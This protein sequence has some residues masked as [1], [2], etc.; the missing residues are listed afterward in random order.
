MDIGLIVAGVITLA[1]A[2]GHATIGL[3]W[4][5]PGIPREALLVLGLVPEVDPRLAGVELAAASM[6]ASGGSAGRSARRRN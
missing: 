5:L 6:G 2:V 3:R 4:V 1:L